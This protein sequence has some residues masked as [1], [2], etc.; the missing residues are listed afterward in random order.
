VSEA[1]NLGGRKTLANN[2]DPSGYAFRMTKI[3]LLKMRA[4]N[5]SKK[6]RKGTQ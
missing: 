3:H 5:A 2:R 1:K 4:S 6:L